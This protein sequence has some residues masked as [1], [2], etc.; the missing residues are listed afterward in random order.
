MSHFAHLKLLTKADAA[1]ILGVCTKTVDNY[2]RD[3][4]LP[5]PRLLGS[6]EY[7]HPQLFERFLAQHF[8]LTEETMQCATV[9]GE[10]DGVSSGAKSP[11]GQ[12]DRQS[13]A[14]KQSAAARQ[15]ARQASLLRKLNA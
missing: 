3:G 2:I 9:E 15:A 11:Q 12:R 6:R 5:P 13:A 4:F 10:G 14:P 7:W 8:G 1:D